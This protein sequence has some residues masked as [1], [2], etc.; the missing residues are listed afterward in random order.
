MSTP[1]GAHA[2]LPA[3]HELWAYQYPF[4]PQCAAMR[5]VCCALSTLLHA[6]RRHSCCCLLACHVSG[7]SCL[8]LC[9]AAHFTCVGEQ[10]L[11][12]TL[13]LISRA[14]LGPF[15]YVLACADPA[16][17]SSGLHTHRR[18]TMCE[19]ACQ[20]LPVITILVMLALGCLLL[21]LCCV[22]L[23]L[24]F[25]PVLACIFNCLCVLCAPAVHD[26]G[27]ESVALA[28]FVK[29]ACPCNS[30]STGR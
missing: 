30:I 10:Y 18:H 13:Q 23:F 19:M 21:G 25:Q 29:P 15:H 27:C 26:L 9:L 7:G 14:S 17:V 12:G 28:P 24:P 16:Q 8:G 2:T 6:S 1:L 22:I 5:T 4:T 20:T 3:C 11:T